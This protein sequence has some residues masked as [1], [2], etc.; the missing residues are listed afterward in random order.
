MSPGGVVASARRTIQWRDRIEAAAGRHGVD[1]ATLEALIF[2]ESAGR[3]NVIAGPTPESAAGLAQILPSTATDL[4]GMSV[5]LAQSIEITERISRSRSPGQ[6]D[7]LEAQRAA[8]DQRFDPE[9]ALDGA[10]RYLE[11]AQE[12]FGGEDF[13]VVSYHMGI[14][15]LESVIEAYGG[16]PGSYAQLYFDS[17]IDSHRAAYEQLIGFGDESAD[18]LWKVLASRE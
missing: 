10:A 8:I 18:Y 3:P 5:D 17:G 9:A 13:A 7:R 11:I 15:N 2:L 14:G 1:P 6:T 16:D 4:L 12:R